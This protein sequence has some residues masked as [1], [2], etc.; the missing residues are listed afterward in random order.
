MV[1]DI[2]SL[3]NL[4]NIILTLPVT[5]KPAL[6]LD[7][8]GINLSRYGSISLISLYIHPMKSAYL[9]D[10]HGLGT[11]AFTTPSSTH[12]SETLKSILESRTIK[13]VFFDV[14]ND[15]DALFAQFNIALDG[16][17]DIQLMEL[18]ARSGW[19]R[20]VMGLGKCITKYVP[21]TEDEKLECDNIKKKG[22]NLFAPEYG[23]NYE[24]FNA[25]PLQEEIINYCL[26]DIVF[27]PVLWETFIVRLKGSRWLDMVQTET[28]KRVKMSQTPEYQPHGDHKHLGP[29]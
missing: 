27:L 2:A 22:R 1:E 21:L 14:R 25:R 15:S 5:P 12:P 20:Y 11:K 6:Y 17:V 3:T 18:A 28:A 8:E 16:I 24:V 26:Q 9:I 7:L 23:G 19:K 4:I 13:K 29:W 10:V